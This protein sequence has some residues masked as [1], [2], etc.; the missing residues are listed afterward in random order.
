MN[1]TFTPYLPPN[2]GNGPLTIAKDLCW[3]VNQDDGPDGDKVT[4][5]VIGVVAWAFTHGLLTNAQK[6]ELLDGLGLE[7]KEDRMGASHLQP[8]FEFTK[9]LALQK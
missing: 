9:G 5:P 2:A 6:R 4:P 7:W 1:K 8:K 3:R